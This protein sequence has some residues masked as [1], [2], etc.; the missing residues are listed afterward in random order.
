MTNRLDRMEAAGLIRRIPDPND[1]R[2]I[3]VEPTKDGLAIWDR[4]VGTQAEREAKFA[5]VLDAK[6]R[7]E[8]H[9]LLRTLMRAFPAGMHHAPP[10]ERGLIRA[11]RSRSSRR[12]C[13]PGPTHW[14][15]RSR[16]PRSATA[17]TI[18]TA[19]PNDDASPTSHVSAC[20][21]P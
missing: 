15:G 4:A 1:R 14:I 16:S 2:G 8:L 5:A 20:S 13:R 12:G 7:E 6:E 17:T 9:R 19:G 10:P 11:T 3:L 21:R 18:V